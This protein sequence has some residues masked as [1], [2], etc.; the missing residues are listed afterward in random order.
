[1]HLTSLARASGKDTTWRQIDR[2]RPRAFFRYVLRGQ[3]AGSTTYRALEGSPLMP[4][5][6]APKYKLP[7]VSVPIMY[8]PTGG[9]GPP[10]GSR[11]LKFSKTLVVAPKPIC[12]RRTRHSLCALA[13]PKK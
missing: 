6:V 8:G 9:V 11:L 4:G 3:G 12:E 2:A 1:V 10:A 7:R 5:T 13:S